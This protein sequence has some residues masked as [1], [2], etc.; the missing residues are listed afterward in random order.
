[1]T[2]LGLFFLVYVAIYLCGCT[3][4]VAEDASI[5]RITA[6]GAVRPSPLLVLL[7][8]KKK[9]YFASWLPGASGIAVCHAEP[10]LDP[11]QRTCPEVLLDTRRAARLWALY[12]RHSTPLVFACQLQAI[13]V[14]AL[15]PLVAFTVT[16]YALVFLFPL[17]LFLHALIVR[18]FVRL[19]RHKI[20][21]PAARVED[22]TTLLLSPPLALHGSAM[23]LRQLFSECHWLAVVNVTCNSEDASSMTSQYL[24]ELEY[25]TAAEQESHGKSS[26]AVE[27]WGTAVRSFFATRYRTPAQLP[28]TPASPAAQRYCPRC[29]TEFTAAVDKCDQCGIELLSFHTDIGVGIGATD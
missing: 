17:W 13:V 23:I 25:P 26:Y 6:F 1:M 2:Y 10:A 8:L 20:F 21:R 15:A 29:L 14:F 19:T 3:V 9:I 28:V 24:R 4:L 5:L 22:I 11:G 18:S 7:G 27:T 12:R 16:P